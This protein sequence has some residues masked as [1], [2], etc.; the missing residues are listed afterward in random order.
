MRLS[1]KTRYGARALVGLALSYPNTAVSVKEIAKKQNL[2]PKYLERIMS[3]LK[4]AELV[5]AVRGMHG[6]YILT[7]PPSQI[8]LNEVYQALEGTTAPVDCVDDPDLCPMKA[9]CPTRDTWVEIKDSIEK[10]LK[11]T[12]LQE[13]AERK[14]QKCS[15]SASIYHI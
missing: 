4:T 14:K 11:G 3:S 10:V 1:T 5:R 15:S 6:G 8:T 9:T 2:S 12:T 13:L 7:R